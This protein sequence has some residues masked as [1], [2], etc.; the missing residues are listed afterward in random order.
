MPRKAKDLFPW[1]TYQRDNPGKTPERS[2]R[3]RWNRLAAKW[4]KKVGARWACRICK[5]PMGDM[6]KNVGRYAEI[7]LRAPSMWLTQPRKFKLCL[8]CYHTVRVLLEKM[9]GQG[10]NHL[11]PPWIYEDEQDANERR[12][13]RHEQRAL[14]AAAEDSD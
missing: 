5:R 8:G 4:A 1:V 14:K 13:E 12:A 2:T 7:N 10:C 11:L 9:E 3:D 6:A